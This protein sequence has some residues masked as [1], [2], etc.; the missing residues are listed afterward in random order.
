MFSI[1][2]PH[3]DH[4][5][6]VKLSSAHVRSAIHGRTKGLAF[7]YVRQGCEYYE[8][9]GRT[10]ALHAG[11]FMLLPADYAFSAKAN[12]KKEVVKGVCVDF[13]AANTLLEHPLPGE[14]LGFGLPLPF[15]ELQATCGTLSINDEAFAQTKKSAILELLCQDIDRLLPTIAVKEQILQRN[16]KKQRTRQELYQRLLLAKYHIRDYYTQRITLADL[17]RVS[18]MSTYR[19]QRLFSMVFGQSPQQMQ[20]EF[21]MIHA[22]KLL[23]DQSSTLSEIAFQLGYSDLAAFSN[24]FQQYYQHRPSERPT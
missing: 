5:A 18:G 6:T 3:Q 2:I 24:Q 15:R 22:K 13:P 16:I 10:V 21:R 1:R 8:F 9:G 23:A 14:S 12:P 11:E 17:A 4:T 20:R 19:L 7:K